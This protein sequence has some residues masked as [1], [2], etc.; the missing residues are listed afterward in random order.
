M[1]KHIII[2]LT[3][4]AVYGCYWESEESF[5]TDQ[6]F[7]DTSF[8]SFSEDILPILTN[9]CFTCH[10]NANAPDYAF[11]IAL[12]DHQ[13]V[14]ASASLIT[15]AINHR[16]GYPQMPK[17]LEKLDTCRINTFEAWENQGKLDN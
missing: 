9:S 8:V 11:G 13:D 6:A 5:Y 7:C 1:K 3:W 2:L 14:S 10:S 17:N 16:E 4:I 12:E 15:G